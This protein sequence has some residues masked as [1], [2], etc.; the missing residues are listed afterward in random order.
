MKDFI[1]LYK[2]FLEEKYPLSKDTGL[3]RYAVETLF[4]DFMKWL[5]DKPNEKKS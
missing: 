3:A 5:E 2:E 1:R 4:Y